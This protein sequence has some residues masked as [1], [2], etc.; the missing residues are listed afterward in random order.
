[1]LIISYESLRLYSKQLG[2]TPIG[3]M[4]CDEGHRLKNSNSQTFQ[5]LFALN[6][7][8]RVIL[9]GTPIQNDLTEYFSLL[10][11][12]CPGLL[13][14]ESEFRKN[15][16]LPI[17]RGRDAFASDKERQNSD[18]KLSEL[19]GI[20]S[21][22]IIRRTQDLLRKYLP[23]KQEH[24]VFCKLAGLQLDMYQAYLNSAEVNRLL[25][26][27]DSQ[28]LRAITHLK[29]LCNHPALLDEHVSRQPNVSDSGKLIVLERMLHKIK[30]T[31]KDKIV[32]IS[33]YTQTL[34]LF[35]NLCGGRGWGCLR[36]D[37]S[38]AVKKRQKLV[39]QFNDPMGTGMRC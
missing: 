39:D 35:E 20:A 4:L 31:T 14:N 38:M 37:G 2:Q 21:R 1:V 23:T 7:K 24:V 33:N 6:V 32:L 22:V 3:L 8:R 5:A 16:E 30:S 29:K 18:E 28:P 27:K 12:A 13:G 15:F 10:N 9:S 25:K 11:F 19:V 36:L 17:L 34:D 26:G